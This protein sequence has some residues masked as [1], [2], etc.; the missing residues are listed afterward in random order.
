MHLEE[1]KTYFNRNTVSVIMMRVRH[2]GVYICTF[3]YFQVQ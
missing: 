2:K 1:V 3:L